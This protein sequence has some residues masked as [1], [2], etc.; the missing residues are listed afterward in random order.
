[1]VASI[2]LAQERNGE[3]TRAD[4]QEALDS[5][6]YEEAG[7]AAKARLE[8]AIQ[9]GNVRDISTVALL[10]DLAEVQRLTGDYDSAIQN[11]ELAVEIVEEKSDML[12]LALIEPLLGLG[13]TYLESGRADVSVEHI[14]R[15]LH[16]RSVNEGPHSI[17]Q[18]ATLEALADAHRSVGNFDD[19]ADAAERMYLIYVRKYSDDALELV[20]ILLKQGH[21]LGDIREWRRQRAVYNEALKIAETPDGNLSKYSIRPL[22]GIG[23]SYATEYFDRYLSADDEDELPSQNL[24]DQA[25][26]YFDAASGF[27]QK[28]PDIDWQIRKDALLSAGDFYTMTDEQSLARLMYRN[29]WDL[30]S[31]T[32]E[33]LRERRIELEQIRPLLK[34]DPDLTVALPAELD[35]EDPD[36]E[37]GTGYIESQFTVTR[38]GKL[39][40]I[41]LLEILPER[42]DAIEAEVKRVL[43]MYIYRPRLELGIATDTTGNTVRFEFPYVKTSPG[44]P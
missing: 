5:G 31:G 8:A 23:N 25:E 18:A 19:A 10:G 17:E 2:S 1:M 15:A 6:L 39:R 29:A 16:V 14:E 9:A 40:D 28:T 34:P 44:Q 3:F 38:R 11:Y 37:L 32:D 33:K 4:Y 7:V 26:N 22:V 36:V 21:I 13:R 12:D 27:V 30:L 24:L 35:L 43:T 41:G 42:N 20:P